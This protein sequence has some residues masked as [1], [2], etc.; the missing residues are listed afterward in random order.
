MNKLSPKEQMDI[1]C[2]ID[3]SLYTYNKTRTFVLL[4]SMFIAISFFMCL[5]IL[6]TD[7]TNLLFR[8][9]NTLGIIGSFLFTVYVFS[10]VYVIISVVGCIYKKYKLNLVYKITR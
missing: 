5:Y 10:N 7:T 2:N 1:V 3:M 6:A 9:I 8:T 4:Y